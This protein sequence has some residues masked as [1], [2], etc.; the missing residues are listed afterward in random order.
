MS[1]PTIGEIRIFA[2]NF[3][4]ANWAFCHGQLLSISEYDALFSL[5]GTIYG[6]DGR[7][8]FA[9]PDLRGRLPMHQGTGTGLSTRVIGQKAGTETVTLTANQMPSHTH[10]ALVSS[11][12]ATTSTPGAAVTLGITDVDLYIAESPSGFMS[13]TTISSAGGNQAHDN[14]QPYLALNFIISLYGL[15]PLRR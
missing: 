14:M 6:G 10:A 8:T 2:G 11:E 1:E 13:G 7:S 3:A 9:L 4:P 5:I 12:T 15:Y